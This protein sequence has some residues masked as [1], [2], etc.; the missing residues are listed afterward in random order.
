MIFLTPIRADQIRFRLQK[1]FE[2]YPRVLLRYL[3]GQDKWVV[4][5]DLNSWRQRVATL[6]VL[7]MLVLAFS[8]FICK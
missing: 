6:R 3:R 5:P 8:L 7:C 4:A 1:A 2:G